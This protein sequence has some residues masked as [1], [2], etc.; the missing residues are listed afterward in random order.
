[1]TIRSSKPTPLPVFLAALAACVHPPG[2]PTMSANASATPTKLHADDGGPPSDLP[3]VLLHSAA[4]DGTHYAAQLRHLRAERRAIALDLR[5]HGRSPTVASFAVEE[6]A[7]DVLAALDA[8]GID[9]FVLVGHSWGGAVAVAVA[10]ARPE[11]VAGLLLLD[12]A[13]DG[14]LIPPDVARG[15]LRSLAED[16]GGVVRAYWASMLGGARPAVRD[17]LM[18]EIAKARREVVVGTLESLLTFD[19]VTPLS[20]YRGPKRTVITPLS[21]RSD[22]Y[23]RLVPDLAVTRVEGTG[24]WLQLDAPDRVNSILDDFLVAVKAAR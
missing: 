22:A 3:V 14:R 19:P 2:A 1:M 9:R 7:T 8:R 21:E 17:R 13:S 15:L 11:R 16:Y 23:H 12:P 18:G 24:H 6:A 20:R 10:G 5:G 4:G